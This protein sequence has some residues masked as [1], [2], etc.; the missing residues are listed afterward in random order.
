M[1]S[2]KNSG[3]NE[4]KLARQEEEARQKRIREG[5]AR[6][7]DIFN[8]TLKGIDAWGADAQYDPNAKYWTADGT[9]WQPDANATQGSGS[10][11]KSSSK[12]NSGPPR[13]QDRDG[14]VYYL[15]RTGPEG[16]TRRI[17]VD[18][19]VATAPAETPESQFQR[20]LREGKLFKSVD[21]D[22][23]FNE[24]FFDHRRQAFL[25]YANP[26]LEDQ[27][28]KAQKE[29]T[30]ALA[31]S[32]TLDSSMRGEKAGE[33]QK[34]YDLNKQQIA[35]QAISYETEARNAVE[36]ARANLVT[37]LNVTG[38]ATGAANSAIARA[39]ALSKPVAFSPI[40]NLFADFT[41]T[42]GTQ[43]AMERANYYSGGQT[44]A[45]YS[46]GLFAPSSS[47]VVNK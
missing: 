34:A 11:P 25:D 44:G 14:R 10:L 33:L 30:F 3:S 1:G 22:G 6:I 16:E 4:A 24:K 35:D 29:L 13:H 23:G 31:R 47:A 19:P 12:A 42:L 2:S 26:Q 38:D 27:Y 7:D 20:M 43:A 32:G 37:M 46:T 5:T 18:Q 9:L 40:S 39:Q 15:Q 21:T 36:D 45:R 17:Y 41:S 28:G 8:G